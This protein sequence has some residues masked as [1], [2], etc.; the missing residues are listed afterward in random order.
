M[1]IV[2][3]L[4]LKGWSYSKTSH[5]ISYY[6][7]ICKHV[8]SLFAHDWTCLL[9]SA[10][11]LVQLKRHNVCKRHVA[12]DTG[13]KQTERTI[14]LNVISMGLNGIYFKVH[15]WRNCAKIVSNF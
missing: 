6:S 4:V 7:I 2:H 9:A 8:L 1:L 10:Y 13:A 3:R 15:F 14:F 11:T 5:K 12:V